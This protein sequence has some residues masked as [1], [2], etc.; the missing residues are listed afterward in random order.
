MRFM[1][2]PG[3]E[4]QGGAALMIDE[5]VLDGV[6]SAYA[7]HIT[8]NCPAGFVAGRAGAI[9]AAADVFRIVITGQGVTPPRPTSPPIDRGRGTPGH[10]D[11][12]DGH[13]RGPRLRARDRLGHPDQQPAPPPT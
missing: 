6:E 12:D 2:Q 10:G 9:M 3:E 11:P 4:G 1:F 7:L 8:P 13:P 5:G